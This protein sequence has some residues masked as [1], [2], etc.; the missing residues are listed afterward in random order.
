[1]AKVRL[2][3]TELVVAALVPAETRALRLTVRVRAGEPI[4]AEIEAEQGDG[5]GRPAPRPRRW[6]LFLVNRI[7]DRWGSDGPVVWF[8]LDA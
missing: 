4:R 8:E 7:A 3:V 2:L 5:D 1:M 6:N